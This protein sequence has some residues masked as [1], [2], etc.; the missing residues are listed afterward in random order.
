[1][2]GW[3]SF[4]KIGTTVREVKFFF[5]GIIIS[6]LNMLNLKS[7]QISDLSGSVSCCL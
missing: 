4:T 5:K 6:V 7:H 2:T 3:A 1:M